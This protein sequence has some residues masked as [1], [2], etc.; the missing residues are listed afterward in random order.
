MHQT[1]TIRL[2]PIFLHLLWFEVTMR[3]HC[4]Q[5]SP[6]W[7]DTL[8]QY[9]VQVLKTVDTAIKTVPYVCKNSPAP[10]RVGHCILVRLHLLKNH[11][12]MSKPQLIRQ[13]SALTTKD[14][15]IFKTYLS[16]CFAV[17]NKQIVGQLKLPVSAASRWY[18]IWECR[19]KGLLLSP[20]GG[21]Q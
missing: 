17:I 15:Y 11:T 7:Y 3:S 13:H 21:G 5:F 6:N 10:L 14:I 20:P 9:E 8:I 4:L 12:P 18:E 1:W 19:V 2:Q 16:E